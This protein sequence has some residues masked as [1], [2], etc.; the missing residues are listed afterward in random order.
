MNNLIVSLACVVCCASI[1]G[2]VYFAWRIIIRKKVMYDT[3]NMP[4]SDEL[5]Q[6]YERLNRGIT[7]PFDQDNT[8]PH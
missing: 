8:L 2:I 6:L 1:W 3:F 7:D 5:H 4:S